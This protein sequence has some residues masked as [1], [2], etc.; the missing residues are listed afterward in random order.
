MEGKDLVSVADLSGND[1]KEL[2]GKAME[3][4]I[5]GSKPLLFGLNLALLFEKPSLRTRVSFDVAMSQ[6]GGRAIYLSPSEVG[7]GKRE[8][9]ED[10]ARVLS[11]YV[12]GMVARTFSQQTVAML[13]RYASVPV[14]NGLSDEEHPCQSLSDLLTIREIKGR[15]EG[16]TIAYVG[17]GNNVANSLMIGAA[18]V[19]MDFR[20]AA[21]EGYWPRDN[22][23]R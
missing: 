18:L 14:I 7:L 22:V 8:P 12:D 15:L 13:A 3:F 17:D 9:V 6:L 1:I 19:G 11:R 20:I 4:K 23:L 21:P 5:R 16:L 2:I 10:V